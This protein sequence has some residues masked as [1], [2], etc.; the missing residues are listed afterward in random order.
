MRFVIIAAKRASIVQ[1]IYIEFFQKKKTCSWEPLLVSMVYL[2][3]YEI[4]GKFY[5]M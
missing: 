4:I 5:E 3:V 2:V 1:N